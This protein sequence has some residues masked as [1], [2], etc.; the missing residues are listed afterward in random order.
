MGTVACP[1]FALGQ[2]TIAALLGKLRGTISMPKHSR[3]QNMRAEP[4]RCTSVLATAR[5][6]LTP[7]ISL[8]R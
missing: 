8:G 4:W 3:G 7:P 1:N 6:S 5:V 2:A